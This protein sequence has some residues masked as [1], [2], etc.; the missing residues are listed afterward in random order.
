MIREVTTARRPGWLGLLVVVGAV[1]IT[2]Q[3]SD[4]PREQT[5]SVRLEHAP[6]AAES[7]RLQCMSAAHAEVA[8]I[9]S[10]PPDDGSLTYR[11]MGRNGLY[12]CEISLH[13]PRGESLWSDS[14][15]VRM[16]GDPVTLPVRVDGNGA[17]SSST[18]TMQ[19]AE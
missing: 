19:T 9:R 8:G 6:P 5:V 11:F 10:A 7:I 4:P 14:R 16:N 17:E 12:R 18:R 1:L 13:G 3:L 2:W 15:R